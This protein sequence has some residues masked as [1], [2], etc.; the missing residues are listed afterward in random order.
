MYSVVFVTGG[1]I[2]VSLIV[3]ALP[4]VVSGQWPHAQGGVPVLEVEVVAALQFRPALGAFDGRRTGSH[5]DFN[6]ATRAD[7]QPG[8]SD[9]FDGHERRVDLEY[10]ALVL[11]AKGREPV[12]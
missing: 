5:A 1:E 11:Q 6:A 4:G 3:P 8:R 2:S 10:G 12:G 9:G 7:A